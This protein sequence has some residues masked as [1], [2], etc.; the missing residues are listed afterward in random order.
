REIRLEFS[1]TDPQGTTPPG[2]GET[3]VGGFFEESITGLHKNPIFTS[4][5]FRLRR[6]SAVPILN[7]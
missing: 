4:G 6:I 7:Q 2:W 5:E 3:I 1:D